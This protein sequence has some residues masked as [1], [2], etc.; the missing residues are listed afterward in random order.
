[1]YRKILLIAAI[2]PMIVFSIVSCKKIPV[3]DVATENINIAKETDR[4]L[5][6][7]K[8]LSTFEND[9]N[10]L[11]QSRAALHGKF[12]T[13][14]GTVCNAT[15]SVDSSDTNYMLTLTYNGL[16]CTG[17]SNFNGTVVLS[18]AK[19]MNWKD[20]GAVVTCDFQQLKITRVI[21][22][23]SITMNGIIN[24]TNASGG[25]IADLPTRKSITNT[26][27][28]INIQVTFD[29]D[30]YS[31]LQ[32]A[33]QRLYTLNNGTVVIT[34]TG[35]HTEGAETGIAEWG[36]DNTGNNFITVYNKPLIMRQNCAYRIGNGETTIT[37]P[38]G[39]SIITFG[40]DAT[41]VPTTCPG[42]TSSYYYKTDWKGINGDA[43]TSLAAY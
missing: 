40:L 23:E 16:N 18:S 22:N 7:S 17:I 41:G 29:D 12:E 38:D 8:E 34:T 37:N 25:K 32:E 13:E 4:Q 26:I 15:A 39:R 2:I 21:D 24:I 30:T 36:T 28:G 31:T 27:T 33:T 14:T 42:T 5:R 1:M 35:T 20:P 9:V 19:T 10:I 11:L 6:F 3:E 43:S